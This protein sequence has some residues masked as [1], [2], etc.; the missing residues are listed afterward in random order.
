MAQLYSRREH[1]TSCKAWTHIHAKLNLASWIFP[2]KFVVV[3]ARSDW[4][5]SE[6]MSQSELLTNYTSEEDPLH[7]LPPEFMVVSST[8][9]ILIVSSAV[10]FVIGS[11]GNVY[12]VICLK[13]FLRYTYSSM[14]HFLLHMCC[15]ELLVV[16]FTIPLDIIWRLSIGWYAGNVTCKDF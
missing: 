9:W 14:H 5:C 16:S 15:T 2:V 1:I 7:P 3:R 6:N 12:A 4:N 10:V 11:V 8:S 13:R